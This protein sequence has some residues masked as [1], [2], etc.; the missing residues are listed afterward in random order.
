MH[1]AQ[2]T[3]SFSE[4]RHPVEGCRLTSGLSTS[5]DR[6]RLRRLISRR[7]DNF[8]TPEVPRKM[9]PPKPQRTGGKSVP[10]E[11]PEKEAPQK[12][13]TPKPRLPSQRSLERLGRRV[14]RWRQG[15]Y[16]QR[17]GD[18][19]KTYNDSTRMDTLVERLRPQCR[20]GA[21]NLPKFGSIGKEIE[22]RWLFVDQVWPV[23]E[24]FLRRRFPKSP[25]ES[26]HSMGFRFDHKLVIEPVSRSE[27]YDWFRR[28]FVRRDERLARKKAAKKKRRARLRRQARKG[29][30]KK[31][32]SDNPPG[33][34]TRVNIPLRR[35]GAVRRRG[36]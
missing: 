30:R 15:P 22:G 26:W 18:R 8:V 29:Q 2:K 34:S 4:K 14:E 21:D 12:G 33:R 10:G 20:T 36:R 31:G 6:R 16:V 24:D 5:R 17:S 9:V 13:E 27:L 1:N 28:V 19:L 32:G 23:V 3:F 25:Y 11:K 7:C 35:R